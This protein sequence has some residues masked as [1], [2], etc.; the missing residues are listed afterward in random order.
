MPSVV[1]DKLVK[2]AVHALPYGMRRLKIMVTA[3][4][5][6]SLAKR[7]PLWFGGLS[8]DE[9]RALLGRPNRLSRRIP[10]LTR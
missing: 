3:A 10:F 7:M 8:A 4:G 6:R 9:R 5:E 1:H 2:P